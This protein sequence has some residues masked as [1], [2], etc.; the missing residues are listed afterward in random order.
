MRA[1]TPGPV[2]AHE[3]GRTLRN[4]GSRRTSATVDDSVGTRWEPAARIARSVPKCLLA[5][6]VRTEADKSALV[7]NGQACLTLCQRAETTRVS[8]RSA[9][10]KIHVFPY[11]PRSGTRAAEWPDDVPPAEKENRARALIALSDRLS[12]EFAQSFLGETVQV[13]VENRQ[14]RSDLLTGLTDN[15]LRVQ[16][17][18]PDHWRGQ[19][20]PVRVLSAG[21]DGI[22]SGVPNRNPNRNPNRRPLDYD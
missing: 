8:E 10:S 20:V 11:S 3:T 7:R 21:S 19:L 2:R 13:L 15:Y 1:S 17:E 16:L 14:R 22:V 18:G 4:R 9:F 6:A 12:L 5:R